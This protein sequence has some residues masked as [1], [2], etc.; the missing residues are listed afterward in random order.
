MGTCCTK[1][2]TIPN[3]DI[4]LNTIDVLPP[5]SV[6]QSKD[7]VHYDPNSVLVGVYNI[8]N[9]VVYIFSSVKQNPNPNI[10][11]VNNSVIEVLCEEQNIDLG[12]IT[13]QIEHF[14]KAYSPL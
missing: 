1:E 14:Q 13:K 3:N 11:W 9:Y 5:F 12:I 7:H 2:E 6:L 10:F 4:C 8:N